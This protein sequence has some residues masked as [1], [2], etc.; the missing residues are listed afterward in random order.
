MPGQN[1]NPNPSTPEQNGSAQ[2]KP[3]TQTSQAASETNPMPNLPTQNQSAPTTSNT[4][5]PNITPTNPT[6]IGKPKKSVFHNPKLIKLFVVL[7]FFV[8]ALG[9]FFLFFRLP[10]TISVNTASTLILDDQNKGENNKFTIWL[11]P[12]K[13]TIRLESRGF[14]PK[15]QTINQTWF[16]IQNLNLVLKKAPNLT[17]IDSGI[18]PLA[19]KQNNSNFLLYF[20]P[21]KN[22]FIKYNFQTKEKLQITPSVFKNFMKLKWNP[23]GNGVIVWLKYDSS[24]FEKTLFEKKELEKNDVATFYY[25]FH[26]Y[27]ITAQSATLWGTDIYEVAWAQ[28]TDSFYF[29]GGEN[30]LGYLGKAKNNGTVKSRLLTNI[31][32]T[33]ADLAID[34]QEN[35]AYILGNNTLYQVNL[36]DPARTLMPMNKGSNTHFVLID[37]EYLLLGSSQADPRYKSDEKY[38]LFNIN[39]QELAAKT[40]YANFSWINQLSPNDLVILQASTNLESNQSSW[41]IGNYLFPSQENKFEYE[42]LSE[43]KPDKIIY[44]NKK[45]IVEIDKK[46]YLLPTI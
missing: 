17:L 23:S 31:P 24:V 9:L 29:L 11:R 14:E 46:L 19:I 3:T 30:N 35:N 44:D 6:T 43:K 25:D 20:N 27:D 16:K 13:H 7:A 26:H 41:L 39:D 28:T 10:I 22:A 1:N 40:Y 33:Q 4:A 38:A 45:L 15:T 36:V 8:V 32:F 21:Q 12:G 42:Y 5:A 2:N 18:E 37:D 34:S